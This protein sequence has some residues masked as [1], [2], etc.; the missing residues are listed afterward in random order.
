MLSL[1][2][3]W[4]N[5]ITIEFL[6]IWVTMRLVWRCHNALLALF[7]NIAKTLPEK[8]FSFLFRIQII[9]FKEMHANVVCTLLALLSREY[10]FGFLH[11]REKCCTEMT[12]MWNG[13]HLIDLTVYWTSK[14]SLRS[15]RVMTPLLSVQSVHKTRHQR[16]GALWVQHS[17]QW[18]GWR[19]QLPVRFNSLWPGRF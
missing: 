6:A 18:N 4:T 13:L 2:I 15:A 7:V 19:V 11:F 16:R 8:L 5:Y 17:R 10:Y 9:S 1:L 12:V 14:C 3:T